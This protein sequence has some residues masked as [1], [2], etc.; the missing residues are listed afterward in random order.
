MG[1]MVAHQA[2]EDEGAVRAPRG[3]GLYYRYDSI[4]E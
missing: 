1:E 2:V 4:L 3:Q